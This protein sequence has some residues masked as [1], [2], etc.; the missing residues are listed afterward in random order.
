MNLKLTS[1]GIPE[2]Q[3]WLDTIKRGVKGKAM[4]WVAQYLV[5]DQSH[6]LMHYSPYR[7]ITIHQAYGGFVSAKQR[8]YVMARIAEGSITPG[9]PHR[10][11]ELQRSWSYKA[12]G[13]YWTI[14]SSAPYAGYVMGDE[15]QAR[16]PALAGWRR[17]IDNVAD[18]LNG[19]FRFAQARVKEWLQ[20]QRR[21]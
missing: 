7:Y 2:I 8:R 4:E 21:G 17:M 3:E 19:A 5:G 15:T 6:G 14:K 11:G 9:Y 20:E 16:L 18:N 12:S 10:T 13:T 1:R